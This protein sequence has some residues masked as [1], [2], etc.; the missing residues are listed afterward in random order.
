MTSPD[1]HTAGFLVIQVSLPKLGLPWPFRLLYLL[2]LSGGCSYCGVKVG[3]CCPTP[4]S[5]QNSP[6]GKE[7]SSPRAVW[8]ASV[9][10]VFSY[11]FLFSSLPSLAFKIMILFVCDVFIVCC[12]GTP[13]SWWDPSSGWGQARRGPPHTTPVQLDERWSGSLGAPGSALTRVGAQSRAHLVMR[14]L[15]LINVIG[16]YFTRH[17]PCVLV[18][19]VN[20]SFVFFSKRVSPP[21]MF[22]HTNKFSTSPTPA[23]CPITQFRSD[24]NYPESAQTLRFR[25]SVPEDGLC[26]RC[27]SIGSPGCPLLSDLTTNVKV[28]TTPFSSSVT[29]YKDMRDSGKCLT[30]FYQFVLKDTAQEQP[31]GRDAWGQVSREGPRASMLSLGIHPRQP[32]RVHPLASSPDPVSW[33]SLWRF[34]YVGVAD[35]IIG[36]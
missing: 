27:A 32:L 8:R 12:P 25:G 20:V 35:E 2:F 14:L 19:F 34:C 6:E 7:L 3:G 15:L 1:P 30:Y 16:V 28:S 18:K 13:A 23:G 21:G 10:M 17:W 24:T 22:S 9:L 4:H 26:F 36:D 5:T 33:R 31:D 29:C 11:S